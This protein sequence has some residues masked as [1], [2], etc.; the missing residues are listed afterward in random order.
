MTPLHHVI[1]E[2]LIKDPGIESYELHRRLKTLATTA[3]SQSLIDA[4]NESDIKDALGMKAFHVETIIKIT[5]TN[6]LDELDHF[7]LNNEKIKG[8][9]F[10]RNK[11]NCGLK[12]AI[13]FYN[14]RKKYYDSVP[15]S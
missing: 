15:S 3:E 5:S 9:K 12:D 8:V 11:L 6:H 14:E 10:I 1:L 4:I 13:D 7:I 2:L